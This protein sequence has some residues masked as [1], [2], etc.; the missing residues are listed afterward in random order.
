MCSINKHPLRVTLNKIRTRILPERQQK[1]RNVR[2]NMFW[3]NGYHDQTGVPSLFHR[4]PKETPVIGE[5]RNRSLENYTVLP[6]FWFFALQLDVYF[7]VLRADGQHTDC[8]WCYDWCNSNCARAEVHLVMVCHKERSPAARRSRPRG[9]WTGSHP[10]LIHSPLPTRV[11]P[12]FWGSQSFLR[13]HRPVKTY[14]RTTG[15]TSGFQCPR[16]LA[17]F[18]FCLQ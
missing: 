4:V 2:L 13:R 10:D 7:M 6:F 5:R 18:H 1:R 12:S 14:S 8:I 9:L 16:L 11:V 15:S 17:Q 3:S